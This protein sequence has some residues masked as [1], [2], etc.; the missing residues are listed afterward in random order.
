MVRGAVDLPAVEAP[1]PLCPCHNEPMRRRSD[2]VGEWRCAVKQRAYD[3]SYRATSTTHADRYA[4]LKAAGLCTKCGQ[5]FAVTETRC[6]DCAV[7][8]SESNQFRN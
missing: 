8:L 2:R 7:K 3:R 6:I 1:R 5:D 4:R